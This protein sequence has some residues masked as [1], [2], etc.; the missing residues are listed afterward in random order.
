M[1]FCVLGG[2]RQWQFG[3]GG[4]IIDAATCSLYVEV[5]LEM[6]VGRRKQKLVMCFFSVEGNKKG[7]YINLL[8]PC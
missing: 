4:D 7:T 1:F 2:G 6:R 8:S 5:P 3:G